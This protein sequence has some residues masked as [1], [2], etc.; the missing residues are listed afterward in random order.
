M[1]ELRINQIFQG[2]AA[3]QYFGEEGTYNTS[4]AI[5]PDFPIVST[6]IRTSGFAVPVGYAKFS[7]SNVTA[8]VISIINNPKDNLTYTVLSNGRLISYDNALGSETLIGT[9]TGGVAS[10]GWYQNNYIYITTPTDVSRYGPL[11]NSPTLT[12]TW[13]TGLGKAALTNTTYPTLRGVTLPNHWGHVHGST[14][15]SYFCDFGGSSTTA[16]GKGLIHQIKTKKTTNEGD[17]DDGSTY[18]ALVLPFGFYPTDIESYSQNVFI[19]G[20]YTTDG[21]INQGKAAF[22]LW[23][24]TNAVTYYQGPTALPDPLATAVLNVDGYI[25]L[26]S[27]NAQNGVRVSKYFG[28]DTVIDVT[29]LEEGMPPFQGAVD[30]LGNRTVWGGFSTN[31]SAGAVVWA[32][33]SKDA[34]LPKGL[35]NVV[36]T[37]SAGTTPIVTA[38][39]FVQQSSNI[40]PKVVA[41]WTDG[42]GSGID[43]Y[44]S[45]ATLASKIRWMINVGQ[46]FNILKIRIPLGGAIDATTAITPTLYFDDLSSSKVL[47]VI[48]NTNFPGSRKAIFKTPELADAIGNN[49]FVLELAWTGTTPLPAAFPIIINYEVKADETNE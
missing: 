28:G 15:S 29:Y 41:A 38:L 43:K 1:A 32:F 23:D 19:T 10:G 14:G 46:K 16:P 17:T 9:V 25:Y 8:S 11:N 30:A 2:I 4:T 35:H 21:T 6:D 33:G 18:G 27:G 42:T 44:S 34:R 26:F 36:K 37:S 49:N 47:T 31:P 12:N 48:N 24:P 22:I 3:S 7:G 5:D 13:W 45:S 40:I 39:K 20:I